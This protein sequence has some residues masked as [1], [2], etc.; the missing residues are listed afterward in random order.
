MQPNEYIHQAYENV[1]HKTLILWENHAGSG[2]VID[3]PFYH[4]TRLALSSGNKPPLT[5]ALLDFI[6]ALYQA[7]QG[8][9]LADVNP[10]QGV[11]FSFF[12]ITRDLYD[13]VEDASERHDVQAI[14]TQHCADHVMHISQ[15]RLVALP[16]QI[17]LAGIPDEHSLTVRK[18][19][20]EA[21]LASPWEAKV[22][23]RYP[24]GE[25][26]QLFWHSTL[27]RY[28]ADVVSPAIR[29]V[30]KRFQ[31]VDFGSV[32]LPVRLVLCNYNWQHVTYLA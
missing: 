30:F 11:H 19:L 31:S 25:I 22:R 17:L 32:S 2:H 7:V 10:E 1:T 13:R 4:P 21:L 20:A 3:T 18:T 15:L 23:A 27:L 8:D 29:D 6:G 5:P 16:N 9:P 26:P 14:F 12:P 28:S 24:A